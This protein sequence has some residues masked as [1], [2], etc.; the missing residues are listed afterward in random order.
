VVGVIGIVVLYHLIAEISG[1]YTE[2]ARAAA[3]EGE[4]A[5]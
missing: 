3:A 2:F 5:S 4:I 1:R